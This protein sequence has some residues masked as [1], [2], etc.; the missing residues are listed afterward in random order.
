LPYFYKICPVIVDIYLLAGCAF[1]TFRDS[2]SALKAEDDLHDKK[3]LP[4]VSIS[5]VKLPL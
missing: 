2:A 4:G 5:D 3:T 1:V